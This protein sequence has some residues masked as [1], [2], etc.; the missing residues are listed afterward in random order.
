MKARA[1]FAAVLA[2]FVLRGL[3]DTKP[4]RKWHVARVV[5]AERETDKDIWKWNLI[6]DGLLYRLQDRGPYLNGMVGL[7]TKIASVSGSDMP[8]EGDTLYILDSKGQ[9]RTMDIL[10]VMVAD[11]P[12]KKSENQH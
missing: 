6:S 3:A 8:G 2:L 5:L 11:D 4:E 12:C 9:E 1:L 10:T 7:Q